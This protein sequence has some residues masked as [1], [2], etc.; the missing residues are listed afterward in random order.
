MPISN[1]KQNEYPEVHWGFYNQF[2]YLESELDKAL[3]DYNNNDNEREVVFSGHSL[4][5]ALA[6]IAALKYAKK[7][8]DLEVN[9]VTFGSPRVESKA[10]AVR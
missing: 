7:Y 10:F 4:G 2:Q 1:T 8:P 3:S 5:G 9:C 6:S